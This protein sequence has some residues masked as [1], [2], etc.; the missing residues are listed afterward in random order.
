MTLRLKLGFGF[1]LSLLAMACTRP[2]AT[3]TTSTVTTNSTNA[4]NNSGGSASPQVT[5]F[6]PNAQAPT[7]DPA[8]VSL[9][10][11]LNASDAPTLAALSVQLGVGGATEM[12]GERA[13]AETLSSAQLLV[14]NGTSAVVLLKTSCGNVRLLGLVRASGQTLNNGWGFAQGVDVVPHAVPG[15]CVRS[16]VV[17]QSIALRSD[18]ATEGAVGVKWEDE[19]GDEVHGPFLWVATLDSTR[20]FAVILQSAPFGGTDDRTGAST[21]GS[22]AVMDELPAPRPLFVEIHPAR[23]GTA[24]PGR[25]RIV[26]RYELR[27]ATPSQPGQLQMV[28]E[29]RQAMQ[30]DGVSGAGASGILPAN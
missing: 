2:S 16:T 4:N 23:R 28:D 6:N 25:E 5:L 20:G 15:S 14:F 3:R 11:R 18:V 21:E 17:A 1:S 30:I 9:V 19:T 8:L 29:Q 26:R 12:T 24:G 22:L 27:S 13:A 7:A 10:S